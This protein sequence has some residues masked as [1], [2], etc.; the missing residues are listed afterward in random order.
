[1]RESLYSD[2]PQIQYPSER[3]S[4]C[5]SGQMAKLSRLWI[6]RE[7]EEV[8]RG[9]VRLRILFIV[10]PI[11]AHFAHLQL[12]DGIPEP[13]VLDTTRRRAS[14]RYSK[15]NTYPRLTESLKRPAKSSSDDC[16]LAR[17]VTKRRL[18][19]GRQ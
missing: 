7:K 4:E 8:V 19:S 18:E 3:Y 10:P 16:T 2:A 12:R 13:D 14:L 17:K 1:M 9:Y 6:G 15:P 5:P 11:V